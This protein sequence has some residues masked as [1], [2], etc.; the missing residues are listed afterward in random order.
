MQSIAL[1][2]EALQL[3][4]RVDD[5]SLGGKSGP[6]VLA[7]IL[8]T[9]LAVGLDTR[10]RLRLSLQLR[11]ILH[12]GITDAADCPEALACWSRT[13]CEQE[14]FML[15]LAPVGAGMHNPAQ[16]HEW[17]TQGLDWERVLSYAVSIE[18]LGFGLSSVCRSFRRLCARPESWRGRDVTF[19]EPHFPLITCASRRCGIGWGKAL[20]LLPALVEA[21]TVRLS[22]FASEVSRSQVLVPLRNACQ[23]VC[24]RTALVACSFCEWHAGAQ[25][26]LPS[27]RR[28]TAHRRDFAARGGGLLLGN[29]PLEP[30]TEQGTR[31]FTVQIQRMLPEERLDIG[32]TSLAP[33]TQFADR[34][35]GSGALRHPTFAED[36]RGSWVIEG[37]GLLVGSHAG[38][39]IRDNRWNAR[40]LGP[41]DEVRLE[42]AA[43]GNMRLFVN[44]TL[45]G[46]WRAQISQSTPVYP[47]L[48]L[49][50]GS[51]VVKLLPDAGLPG[52][53][54]QD[55]PN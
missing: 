38:L 11:S 16:L 29:G 27:P 30:D 26:E 8:S 17:P 2:T 18:A 32:V 47:V 15:R 1:R 41:G 45:K 35:R 6:N 37:S 7:A 40:A 5:L 53:A 24:P 14:Q 31:F 39:R 44:G 13:V 33:H 43:N 23:I 52:R 19:R 49:F 21:R 51:P 9:V 36:L 42:V 3:H 28:L 54:R 22:S 4:S 34:L 25:I 55:V 50:E 10:R 12:E 48:D 46:E 20:S